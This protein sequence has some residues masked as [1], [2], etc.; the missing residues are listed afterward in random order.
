MSPVGSVMGRG[1]GLRHDDPH[2]GDALQPRP[3]QRRRCRSG[4]PWPWLA[5][6]AAEG[7]R[8]RQ[9]LLETTPRSPRGYDE[10]L[11]PL[12]WCSG[13]NE[14]RLSTIRKARL[15]RDYA[16]ASWRPW[17][18]RRKIM[19]ASVR[20]IGGTASTPSR[21]PRR[22][23]LRHI[24]FNRRIATTGLHRRELRRRRCGAG[25][26]DDDLRRPKQAPPPVV[27]V[28]GSCSGVMVRIPRDLPAAGSTPS[29]RS[30][31]LA[32]LR[33]VGSSQPRLF[34]GS[35]HRADRRRAGRSSAAAKAVA[36]ASGGC[37]GRGVRD[38]RRRA[39]DR[40]RREPHADRLQQ[41]LGGVLDRAQ[42]SAARAL[43]GAIRDRC[44]A[45]RSTRFASRPSI[46][47]FWDN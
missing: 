24:S 42:R 36:A 41:A 12:G 28:R 6:A 7:R 37:A 19:E 11:C 47:Y 34:S 44:S 43:A 20:A 21:V 5:P 15:G 9:R 1:G 31:R 33:A 8:A 2:H 4:T 13:E 10:G 39:H 16:M 14:L 23:A 3:P 35:V 38:P 26:A 45:K 32:G 46:R 29:R 40:A 18:R 25:L 22:R 30:R 27:L 17:G